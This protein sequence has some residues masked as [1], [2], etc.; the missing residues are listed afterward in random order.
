MYYETKKVKISVLET[1]IIKVE[2]KDNAV[3]TK[4]D[5]AKHHE[6][7]DEVLPNKKKYFLV[8]L[9]L[10]STV[11]KDAVLEFALSEKAVYKAGEAI[12]TKSLAHRIFN[13]IYMKSIRPNYPV[14]FFSK[15]APALAWLQ[16]EM[17]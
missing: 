13:H 8:I 14:K 7:F 4:A 11:K 17:I 2:I 9:G 12:V 10:N 5:L 1:G 6:I 15:E 16:A 3:L